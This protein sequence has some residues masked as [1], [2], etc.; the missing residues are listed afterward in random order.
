MAILYSED[1]DYKTSL[2]ITTGDAKLIQNQMWQRY[3]VHL[4]SGDHE[5]NLG[6]KSSGALESD[7]C[8]FCRKPKDEVQD[9]I[10]KL[11][12]V[13]DF[14]REKLLFEPAEPSF[15]LSITR[16]GVTGIKVE[17]WLDPGNAKTGIYRWDGVGIRFYTLQEHLISFL[18]EL[19]DEFAC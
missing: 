11:K 9:L 10:D 17:V 14:D 16:S 4:R 6:G 19:E 13:V 7:N 15:E 3:S 1:Q 8:L 2:R 18:K 12:Q 5:I